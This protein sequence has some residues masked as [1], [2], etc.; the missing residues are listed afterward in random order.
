MKRAFFEDIS[1]SSITAGFLVVLISYAGPML[2]FFQAASLAQVSNEVLS[3]WV[4]A[5]SFGG[6]IS[7]IYLSWKYK[8]P[9]ITAWS[10]PGA[11]LLIALFPH[12]SVNEAISSYITAAM[13]ILLIGITG[14]FDKLIKHIPK[15]I[16][17][18]MMAGILFQ[19][20]INIFKSVSTMPALALS[21][22]GIYLIFKRLIPKF[23]I[24]VVLFSGIGLA[25]LIGDVN[26]DN[27]RLALAH[28]KFITPVWTW[29]STFSFAIPL[30]LVSLTGQYL[31]G[32]AILKLS[33]YHVPA[34]PIITFTSFMS[35]VTAFFGGITTT[36][37]AITA[38]LCT[39]KEANEDP[40]KRYVAGI[41]SG[42]FFLIGGSLAGSIV[43]I[44]TSLPK[45]LI[46]LL[47]GLALLGAIVTSLMSTLE[48]PDHREAAAITFL[49]TA[50]GMTFL[51]LGSA[52]WGI[53]IGSIA[54]VVFDKDLLKLK[55]KE[56]ND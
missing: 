56:K 19:F 8:M 35:L 54:Y 26:P 37:A 50:S 52:F 3:S 33:N 9:I 14:T 20:G 45:E 42:V 23:A 17:A 2:I 55:S 24:L 49:A 36:T 22:I 29:E 46:A 38:T 39:G 4:W 16:A 25:Y 7:G 53:V 21:M 43:L 6:G 15:G 41:F 27:F 13:I 47:A 11:A 28:P 31:P 12:M 40:N 5:V 48:E 32:M 30:V 1:P 34:K 51:G 18:G 10:A 44:F